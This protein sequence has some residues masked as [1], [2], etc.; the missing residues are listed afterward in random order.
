MLDLHSIRAQPET[1]FAPIHGTLNESVKHS[2]RQN[3]LLAA[4]PR[5]HYE[6]LLPR[7]E[8]VPLPMGCTIHGANAEEKHL[9]FLS[10]GLVS[11]YQEIENGAS[12]Q[13]AETG[14]EG[15]IGIAS[16]LG[17]ASTPSRAVVL[18]AGYAYRLEAGLVKQEVDHDSPLARLLISYI[19]ALITQ[20]GQ[21]V[22][23]NRHHSLEQR[24]CRWL[25]SS[26]DRL[27]SNEVVIT[28]E[29]I[30]YMLGVRREGITQ[31]VGRLEEAR[32]IHHSRGHTILLDR[33]GMKAR[34]CE[35]YQVVKRE[36]DRLLLKYRQAEVVNNG[37]TH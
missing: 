4:L 15:V 20:T 11:R 31:A 17:G 28:Q 3:K 33:P 14:R 30:A 7:L 24:L 32:L 6:R 37:A 13:F 25:L 22:V 18:S 23:C 12:T 8:P 26:L 1:R 5:E 34:A 19:Q 29:V 21:I 2:P 10:G 16:F 27:P 36:Y 9:Y 35:C